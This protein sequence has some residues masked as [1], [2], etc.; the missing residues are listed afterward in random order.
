MCWTPI[1]LWLLRISTIGEVKQFFLSTN[2]K[3][4][5]KRHKPLRFSFLCGE[6]MIFRKFW[7]KTQGVQPMLGCESG[8][9]SPNQHHVH[10]MAHMH[11]HQ[12]HHPTKH[13]HFDYKY[14]YVTSVPLK[15]RNIEKN[16]NHPPNSH[17]STL[18]IRALIGFGSPCLC[19]FNQNL[20]RQFY[21][22]SLQD[23][24]FCNLLEQLRGGRPL[25]VELKD[26]IQLTW[27]LTECHNPSTECWAVEFAVFTWLCYLESWPWFEGQIVPISVA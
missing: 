15:H 11:N 10:S 19:L 16:P 22:V 20:V 5:Y 9:L 26:R 13:L 18:A 27:A 12:S 2:N 3:R 8:T 25:S 14:M 24:M 23:A 6:D 21:G 17:R 7:P 1:S 4:I